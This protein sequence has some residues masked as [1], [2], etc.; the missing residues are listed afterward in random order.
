MRPD[1]IVA[2]S[3]R[4]CAIPWPDDLA[5]APLDRRALTR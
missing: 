5:S 2:P 4:G 3:G 1:Y